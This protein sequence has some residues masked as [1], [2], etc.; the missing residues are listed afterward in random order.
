MK[1]IAKSNFI[2][3]K[4]IDI[5]V[6]VITKD[7]I[8]KEIDKYLAQEIEVCLINY[9]NPYGVELATKNKTFLNAVLNSTIVFN[10]GIGITLATKILNLPI[11]E[12]MTV[13]GWIDELFMNLSISE[14]TVFFIGDEENVVNTFT[15][16]I[17]I[18]YPKLNVL[19]CNNGFFKKEGIENESLIERINAYNPDIIIT[20]MGMPIQ[21]IWSYENCLKLNCKVIFSTGALFRHYINYDKS[22]PQFLK[23]IGLEWFFRLIMRP[24]KFAKRYI[25]GIP[26]FF[27]LILKYKFKKK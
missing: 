9:A 18:K 27:Y 23:N 3:S 20:G 14:K 11:G 19:G 21:E 1:H 15:D 22:A 13:P 2:K 24:R 16:T 8:L 25:I 6:D 17:K 7:E 12:R 4:I 26:I 5:Y 10:D